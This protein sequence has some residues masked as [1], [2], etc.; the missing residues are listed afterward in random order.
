MNE[1]SY[2]LWPGLDA[3]GGLGGVL[4]SLVLFLALGSL[5]GGR[6]RLT[7]ADPVVGWGLASL[8][9]TLIGT[10]LPGTVLPGALF[11]VAIGLAG[12]GGGA[13]GWAVIADRR[14]GG[15]SQFE[16]VILLTPLLLYI[17]GGGISHW[18]DFTHWQVNASYLF[19]N[20]GFPGA[21][22]APTV[23]S[24]AGYPYA[25]ALWSYFASLAAEHFVEVAGALAN[26][27]LLTV[28]GVTIVAILPG[29]DQP[30]PRPLRWAAAALGIVVVIP[31]NPSFHRSSVGS[32]LADAPTAVVVAVAGILV[33][34]LLE[35]LRDQDRGA[36]TEVGRALVWQAG[37]AFAVLVGLKQANLILMLLILGAA[38]V[39]AWRDRV[40][41]VGRFLGTV[42]P[43][44]LPPALLFAVWHW[45]VGQFGVG[46]EFALNPLGQWLIAEIPTILGAVWHNHIADHLHYYLPMAL[47]AVRGGVALVRPRTPFDRLAA[48]AAIVFVGYSGFLIFAYVASFGGGESLRAASF[49]RYSIHVGLLGVAAAVYGLAPAIAPRLAAIPPKRWRQACWS[50]AVLVPVL[51][52]LLPSTLFRTRNL[53]YRAVG[54]YLADTLPAG[55]R[56]AVVDADGGFL[57][58]VVRYELWR[59]GRD[60]RDL[61]VAVRVSHSEHQ[62][63]ARRLAPVVGGLDIGFA[64]IQGPDP[65]LLAG[66]GIAAD[67]LPEPAPALLLL[68]WRN[69]EWQVQPLPPLS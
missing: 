39:I 32:S 67:R 17:A 33:W 34:R 60:D 56:L 31:L 14:V 7:A 51:I 16:S 55:A 3:L 27:L 63:L 37:P 6:H 58:A 13:L 64:L 43:A 25:M 35:A 53:T 54:H 52:L 24:H 12:L 66:F 5:V 28:A 19:R 2:T 50:L 46:G 1:Q 22:M 4:A 29:G 36:G 49:W 26:F 68:A 41:G 69:G 40:I 48:L 61:R 10:L 65:G 62:Q 18:D 57:E 47:L 20:H 59:P 21:G 30:R 8:A 15:I 42:W 23:S 38:A 44:L 11:W 45:Y 9:T